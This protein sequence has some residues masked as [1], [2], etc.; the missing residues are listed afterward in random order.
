MTAINALVRLVIRAIN[1]ANHF[2]LYVS[3]YD[4]GHA[5]VFIEHSLL[6]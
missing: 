2:F 5:L 1:K 4:R 3:W 6:S